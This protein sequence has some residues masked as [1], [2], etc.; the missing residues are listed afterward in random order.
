MSKYIPAFPNSYV[1]SEIQGLK[2]SYEGG[3]TL[4]DCF[5]ASVAS[6][7]TLHAMSLN[8]RSIVTSYELAELMLLERDKKEGK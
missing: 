5:A 6:G 2:Y 4:R 7:L 3:M 1:F 8:D